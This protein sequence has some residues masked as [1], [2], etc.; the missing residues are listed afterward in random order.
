MEPMLCPVL[1]DRSRELA[2]LTGV[3]DAAGEGRGRAVFVVGDPGIG[4]SRLAS[5]AIAV[6]AT[7]GFFTLTGRATQSSV[8]VPFRPISEALLGAAR[9]GIVPDAPGIA[10]YRA[11]LGTLVPEWSRPGDSEAEVSPVIFGE[12]ILRILSLPGSPGGMLVLEDLQWAD[13][14]TVAILEYLIDNIRSAP[15]A[16]VITMQ[17]GAPSAALDLLRSVRSRR[18][19]VTV[20]VP[21]LSPQ[22]VT[23]M[24]ARC[25]GVEA[26]P[27]SVSALLADCEGLPFAVEEILAAAVTSGELTRGPDGWQVDSNIVTGLPSSI[28]RSVR[29]RIAVLGGQARNVIVSAAVLGRQFDWTL[30]PGVAEE[31]QAVV[32]GTLQRAC[33]VQL[34]EPVSAEACA[35]RFRHSLTRDAIVSDLLPPELTSRSARAATAV[36]AAHPGLPGPSC[37]LAAEL[38]ATAGQPIEAARLLLTAGRRAISQGALGSAIATLRDAR[39]LL[40]EPADRVAAALD[41]DI[42]EALAEA[43]AISGDH[44]QLRGLVSGLLAKLGPDDLRREALIRVRAASTRPEDNPEAVAAHLA[45]ARTIAD[46][47]AEPELASRVDVASARYAMVMGELDRAEELARRSL[48][49]ADGAGL[50]GW[51]AEVGIESLGVIGRR[52]RIHDPRAARAAFER[53]HKIADKRGLGAWRIKALHDLATIDMLVDGDTGALRDVRVL[54]HEAGLFTIATMIDLQLANLCSLSTDLDDAL[55]AARQCERGSQRIGAPRIQAMAV[56]LRALIAAI[57][58]DAKAVEQ[59]TRSAEAITLG[60]PEV[61]LTTY[62]QVRVVAAL[63]RDDVERAAGYAASANDYAMQLLRAPHRARGFYSPVQ[64]PLIARGR[65]WALR[66]LLAA[67]SGGAAAEAIEQA[68]LAGAAG[69]WNRGCLAYAEAVLAGQAGQSDRATALAAEAAA[70][71]APFAPWWNHLARRLVARSALDHGWG[72]PVGWMREAAVSFEAT[73]HGRVASACRGILRQAGVPVPRSGRGTAQVPAQLQRLGVTSREMDVYLLV[74]RGYSNAEIAERL[75]ISPKTV[76]THVANLA[77]KTGQP[78]RRELVAHAARNI[79][80]LA[81]NAGFFPPPQRAWS[82][83]LSVAGR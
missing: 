30:L 57:R 38:R 3:L 15:V 50:T 35:F 41:V 78:G 18:A 62:C 48:A 70:S 51:A 29:D 28:V 56:C 68:E 39:T 63:F 61:L 37:E 45:A 44:Q 36:E 25:L 23:E 19:A 74:G 16:C 58:C 12:A 14:E 17:D 65:S 81:R 11:A 54:A 79:K 75:F 64:I 42:A 31:T 59:A 82:R 40:A 47:L 52:Q 5:E 9:A 4:K 26:V 55:A 8:P 2:S 27:R 77:A 73:G 72:D 69:T 20:E 83:Q 24:A 34:I 49:A 46:Q 53:A 80:S 60:D 21:R 32:L 43:L 67:V 76:E 66:A 7:R 1:I 71:F 10:D 22:A 6:A 33:D 13:P